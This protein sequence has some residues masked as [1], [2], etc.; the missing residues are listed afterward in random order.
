MKKEEWINEVLNSTSGMEKAEAGPFL[1]E[2]IA[3]RIEKQGAKPAAS[4]VPNWAIIAGFV[5]VINLFSI[6]F[7][8]VKNKEAKKEQ[9]IRELRSE[10]GYNTNN[11]Y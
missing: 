6:G 3:N 5:V 9:A 8:L 2:K 4:A 11:I 1:F 7:L 10:M